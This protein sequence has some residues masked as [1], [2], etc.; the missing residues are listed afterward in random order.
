MIADHLISGGYVTKE[1]EGHRNWYHI[2]GDRSPPFTIPEVPLRGRQLPRAFGGLGWHTPLISE[3]P[4]NHHGA[5]AC[6]Q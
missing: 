5:T 6:T 2:H 4:G 3:E 1:R